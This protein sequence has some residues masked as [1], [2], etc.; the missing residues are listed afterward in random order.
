[1]ADFLLVTMLRFL[2]RF[3]YSPFSSKLESVPQEKGRLTGQCSCHSLRENESCDE[4]E[5]CI[6]SEHDPET[7]QPLKASK[8]TK[9]VETSY[10][11]EGLHQ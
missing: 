11:C 8:V 9:Q 5:E 2:W 6:V 4:E 1:M 3:T 7:A 10:S